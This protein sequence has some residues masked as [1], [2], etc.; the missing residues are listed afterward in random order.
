MQE[1]TAKT[2]L[3][4]GRL[5]HLTDQ[6]ARMV[7]HLRKEYHYTVEELARR[8]EVGERAIRNILQGKTHRQ[9]TADYRRGTA[10][11]NSLPTNY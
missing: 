7:C 8:M 3:T 11:R 5:S 4:R 10:P 2:T 1:P 9:A 6:D